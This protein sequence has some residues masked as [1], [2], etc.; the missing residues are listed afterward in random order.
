MCT[1]ATKFI[2]REQS[3]LLLASLKILFRIKLMQQE[4]IRKLMKN[5]NIAYSDS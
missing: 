3:L 4:E 5:K 1:V 2:T